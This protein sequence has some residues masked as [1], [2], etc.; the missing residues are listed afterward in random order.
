MMVVLRAWQL[1]Q[2]HSPG[3]VDSQQLVFGYKSLK[4]AINGCNADPGALL[5]GK[6]EDFLHRKRSVDLLE[7]LEDRLPLLRVSFHTRNYLTHLTLAIMIND[8]H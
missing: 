2:N 1:I 7:D 3:H 6:L 5:L 8:Y 4:V